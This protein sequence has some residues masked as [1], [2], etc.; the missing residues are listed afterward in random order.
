MPKILVKKAGE[1][2]SSSR[3]I[4]I[5]TSKGKVQSELSAKYTPYSPC[6]AKIENLC[7]HFNN[8]Y[9]QNHVIDKVSKRIGTCMGMQEEVYNIYGKASTMVR[10]K[11]RVYFKG[12]KNCAK[13]LLLRD[14]I[15]LEE[16]NKPLVHM[17][18]IS[19][20]TGQLIDVS[21]GGIAYKMLDERGYNP[22]YLIDTTN[23]VRFV[24]QI[25][26]MEYMSTKIEPTTNDFAITTRGCIIIRLTW[27][28][29]EWSQGLEDAVLSHCNRYCEFL[30]SCIRDM[31]Q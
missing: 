26:D 5:L 12:C 3:V 27:A 28:A 20:Y 16:F 15:G 11:D 21:P 29:I 7:G 1:D 25:K 2:K 23:S 4:T 10:H 31:S 24:M 13:L 19:Y 6:L 8:V 14:D 22:F 17:T 18:V 9:Y 30:H